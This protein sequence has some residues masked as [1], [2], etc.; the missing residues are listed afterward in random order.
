M[1]T[2]QDAVPVG[3]QHITQSELDTRAASGHNVV[4]TSSDIVLC[5]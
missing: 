5:K 1:L 4:I 2:V 3:E